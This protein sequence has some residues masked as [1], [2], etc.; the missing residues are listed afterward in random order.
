MKRV[1][2]RLTASIGSIPCAPVVCS[3]TVAPAGTVGCAGKSQVGSGA[4]AA[5]APGAAASSAIAPA[6]ASRDRTRPLPVHIGGERR[7]GGDRGGGARPVEVGDVV[8]GER[9]RVD[10]GLE[11]GGA[12]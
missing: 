11:R 10:A 1:P 5:S 12:H 3:Q 2:R 7:L 8:G 4:G 9:G 6:T